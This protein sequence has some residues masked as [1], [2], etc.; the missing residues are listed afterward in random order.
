MS[1]DDTEASVEGASPRELYQFEQGAQ[2]WSF[3]GADADVVY[4]GVTY[5]KVTMGRTQADFSQE[6]N[7]GGIEISMP[8][9]NPV[10]QRYI[11]FQPTTPLY[12]TVLRVH[13]D[14]SAGIEFRGRMTNINFDGPQATLTCTPLGADLVH[15]VPGLTYQ[16]QC[17]HALYGP[18]CDL[19]PLAFRTIATVSL[20]EG[21]LVHAAA[22]AAK[23]DGWFDH[24]WVELTAG[25]RAGDR[26][27]I[28][29]HAGEVLTLTAPFLGLVA[30][31][32]VHAFAGCDRTEATC[33][34]K[35]DNLERHLGFSR[36]PILNPHLGRMF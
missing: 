29:S 36:I 24:G 32:T 15:Q 11:G 33:A 22:F 3:T 5:T 10:A 34:A 35:F 4:A 6:E 28:S 23:P 12:V 16:T 30:G 13:R 19:D 2:S 31:D 17:N 27:F 18:G 26:R 14:G 25:E 21:F 9:A 20:V 1:F 8:A 7:A